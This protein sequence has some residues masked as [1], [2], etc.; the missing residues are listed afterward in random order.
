M[1]EHQINLD[2][3]YNS[4]IV[5]ALNMI[6]KQE[7]LRE[8]WLSENVLVQLIKQRYDFSRYEFSLLT[9]NTEMRKANYL[10]ELLDSINTSGQYRMLRRIPRNESTR[11][12]YFGDKLGPFPHSIHARSGEKQKSWDEFDKQVENDCE[13]LLAAENEPKRHRP[14][15]DVD[16]K[17]SLLKKKA[18]EELQKKEARKAAI[19]DFFTSGDA[20]NVFQP[21]AD[22]TVRECINRRIS[23]IDKIL[24]DPDHGHKQVVPDPDDFYTPRERML[25]RSKLMHVR[26]A[27]CLALEQM[28]K[29]SWGAICDTAVSQLKLCG[30][31]CIGKPLSLQK[32]HRKFRD[33]G[34]IPR[35]KIAFRD[36][37]TIPRSK[38]ASEKPSEL[39]SPKIFELFPRTAQRMVEYAKAHSGEEVSLD[40]MTEY[41]NEQL[42]PQL[43]QL[44]NE[45]HRLN[46]E[47]DEFVTRVLEQKDKHYQKVTVSRYIKLLGFRYNKQRQRY[48]VPDEAPAELPLLKPACRHSGGGMTVLL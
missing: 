26:L 22:E 25:V 24:L 1:S 34:T 20:K 4:L 45:R 8:K 6:T 14:W 36:T 37:G 19:L 10:I 17:L 44:F 13:E 9:F 31:P 46:M 29:V 28:P 18:D 5:E 40:V 41:T 3:T 48:S 39:T 23:L 7:V 33:T 42:V 16:E 30:L 27:Y 32:L 38:M 43:L 2:S 21:N 12:Y 15:D 47:K 35:L 11:Y